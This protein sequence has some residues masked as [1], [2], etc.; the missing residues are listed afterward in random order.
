LVKR[1]VGAKA[2]RTKALAYVTLGLYRKK[3]FCRPA[4]TL[5]PLVEGGDAARGPPDLDGARSECPGRLRQGDKVASAKQTMPGTRHEP[6]A[7]GQARRP[8]A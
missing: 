3:G 5:A 7:Q 8:F 2:E 4:G 6:D 1:T